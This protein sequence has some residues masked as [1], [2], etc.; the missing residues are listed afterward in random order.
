MVL[1]LI[2]ALPLMACVGIAVGVVAASRRPRIWLGDLAWFG[3]G[4]GIS[5]SHSSKS[6]SFTMPTGRD[7]SSQRR[8]VSLMRSSLLG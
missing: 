4:F 6:D 7:R 3:A 8:L 1:E 2:V 5:A